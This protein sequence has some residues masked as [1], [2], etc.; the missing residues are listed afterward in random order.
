MSEAQ[1][2]PH[3]DKMSHGSVDCS[4]ENTLHDLGE[5]THIDI[6]KRRTLDNCKFFANINTIRD[7]FVELRFFEDKCRAYG[8][9]EESEKFKMLQRI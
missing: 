4:P 6:L 5:Y 2:R 9:T 8:I 3:N 7:S 1:N